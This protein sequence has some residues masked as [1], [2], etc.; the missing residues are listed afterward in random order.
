[1]ALQRKAVVEEPDLQTA[2]PAPSVAITPEPLNPEVPE[3]M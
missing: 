3:P 2:F 1:M